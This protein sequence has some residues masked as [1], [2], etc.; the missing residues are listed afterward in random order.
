MKFLSAV[1]C[2]WLVRHRVPFAFFSI[3]M[4]S[5]AIYAGGCKDLGI[6]EVYDILL[7]LNPESDASAPEIQRV[8]VRFVPGDTSIERESKVVLIED[9][10]GRVTAEVWRSQSA[11]SI[12]QQLRDLRKVQPEACDEALIKSISIEHYVANEGCVTTLYRKLLNTKVLVVSE[13]AIYLDTARYEVRVDSPM[14]STAFVLYGPDL[15]KRRPHPLIKWA[16]AIIDCTSRRA[17][18]TAPVGPTPPGR[19]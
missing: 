8:T 2:R 15:A 9:V 19:H 1:S 6:F 7:P 17:N 11:R 12:Q 4:L 13:S 14:N 16:A 3:L 5:P 18:L 10:H